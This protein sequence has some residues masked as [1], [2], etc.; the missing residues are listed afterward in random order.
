M[1]VVAVKYIEGSGWIGIK[2]RDRNYKPVIKIRKSFRNGIERLYIWDMRTRWTEGLNEHGIGIISG[3]VLVKS[4][5]K[6]LKMVRNT[7]KHK[8]L[9]AGE[10]F[11]PSGRKIRTALFETTAEAALKQVLELQVSGN[12]YIFDKD[13]CFLVEARAYRDDND[14]KQFEAE[15][16]EIPKDK[17]SVRTN[18][19]VLLPHTGYQPDPNDPEAQMKRKS[20]VLRR[21]K[22]SKALMKAKT[23][24]DMW[25]A[26]SI[27]DDKN[28]QFNPLRLDPSRSIKVMKTTGQ[29]LLEPAANVLH[30]RPIWCETLFDF[31]KLNGKKENTYFEISSSKNLF[32]FKEYV[33]I[34]GE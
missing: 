17:I 1:C 34:Y 10:Y 6:E 28:P 3:S 31:Q 15:W 19:G 32:T 26:M 11:C 20:S 4:D 12:T 5:E 30:Y 21:Q 13:R 16:I 24:E 22:V 14:K 2:N 27:T 23:T 8:S 18:H 9:E 29:I 7:K 25:E 33:D